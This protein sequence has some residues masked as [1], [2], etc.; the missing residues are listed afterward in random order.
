ML[1][2][3]NTFKITLLTIEEA[4][5][6][7]NKNSDRPA[8][9]VFKDGNKTAFYSESTT[10]GL[11]N[12]IAMAWISSYQEVLE[13]IMSASKEDGKYKHNAYLGIVEETEISDA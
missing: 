13:T 8:F 4:K 12:N 3:E 10:K 2:I 9:I 1:K 6:Q 5:A 7:L 11:C